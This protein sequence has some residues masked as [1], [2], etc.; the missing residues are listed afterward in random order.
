MAPILVPE[1]VSRFIVIA[2]ANQSL[3]KVY[4]LELKSSGPKQDKWADKVSV[5]CLWVFTTIL[6]ITLVMLLS[7]R[8]RAKAEQPSEVST[9]PFST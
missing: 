5:I 1:A 3:D 7:P 2:F 6:G 8:P 4:P 9:R